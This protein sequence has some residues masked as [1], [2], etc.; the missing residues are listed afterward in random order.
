MLV[1]TCNRLYRSAERLCQ[2]SEALDARW[3]DGWKTVQADLEELEHY[4]RA[5]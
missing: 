1:D 3:Q 4:M 5:A 2:P